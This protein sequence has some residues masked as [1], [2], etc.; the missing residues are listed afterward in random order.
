M[1]IRT[2][3]LSLCLTNSGSF[4]ITTNNLFKAVQKGK[5]STFRPQ[6]E[7]GL[8]SASVFWLGPITPHH[9]RRFVWSLL[10]RWSLVSWPEGPTAQ[11]LPWRTA[12]KQ[13]LHERFT[14]RC[15][16][17]TP[18]A[19]IC[20]SELPFSH[21]F[22]YVGQEKDQAF[23]LSKTSLWPRPVNQAK[24]EVLSSSPTRKPFY[25]VFPSDKRCAYHICFFQ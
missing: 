1:V 12:L 25:T 18:D 22:G 7:K 24:A 17:P 11:L 4:E 13:V 2:A 9:I 8:V 10:H 20:L 3:S 21:H 6:P 15:F 16:C 14:P 23:C 19:Q 5:L